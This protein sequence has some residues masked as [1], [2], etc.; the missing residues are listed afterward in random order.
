[1]IDVIIPENRNQ[2][3][4][5]RYGRVCSSER[6]I[7][8]SFDRIDLFERQRDRKK[9]TEANVN[10]ASAYLHIANRVGEDKTNVNREVKML[11]RETWLENSN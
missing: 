10:C 3:T 6:R 1:M 11:E 2:L 9:T 8:Q 5:A 7:T 4:F